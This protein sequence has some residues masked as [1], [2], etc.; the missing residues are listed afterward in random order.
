MS[1]ARTANIKVSQNGHSEPGKNGNTRK[2]VF[3][4][5]VLVDT[6]SG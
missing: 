1:L 5:M 4:K 6:N 3:R 2:T